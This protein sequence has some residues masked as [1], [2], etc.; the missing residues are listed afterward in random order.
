MGENV[1]QT[2]RSGK[3]NGFGF[4][5]TGNFF[6][7]KILFLGLV[8]AQIISS[9]H[10]YLSNI[11][12]LHSI[13]N[14]KAAG[15]LTVPNQNIIKSL[16]ELGPAFYGGI[17]FTLTTGALLSLL[18]LVSAFMWVRF[19]KR[20]KN[21]LIP[22]IAIWAGLIGEININGFSPLICSYFL[23]IPSVVFLIS[24]RYMP[25][26]QS[27]K[28]G[29]LTEIIPVIPV[30]AL[31][32][33]WTLQ[34]NSGIFTD[35]RDHLL[36]SNSL[37]T[38]INDFYYQYTLYPAEAIKSL[39]QKLI[40]TYKFD[41]PE[42]NSL[43]DQIRVKLVNNDYLQLNKN[44]EVD[45]DIE[46][47]NNY[48]ELR[49]E[50]K[51]ILTTLSKDF[52]SDPGKTLSEFS[53]RVDRQDFFRRFTFISL[54]SGFP[55]AM[56]I[57]FYSMLV[58]FL[59]LFF[60]YRRA[61]TISLY[62]CLAIAIFLSAFFNHVSGKQIDENNLPEALKSA[63]WQDKVMALRIID[64]KKLDISGF[65][66]YR[67]MLSSPHIPVRYWLAKVLGESHKPGTF[68]DLLVLMDD[69]SPNV[70]CM[71]YY[72]TGQR[73]SKKNIKE[74]LQRIK[75]SGHWYEQWY[76]YKA[77]RALGWKQTISD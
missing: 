54:L 36:L 56:I 10:V 69:P 67:E 34:I 63:R 61:S 72:S 29:G 35:I 3:T 68:K 9:I 2:D 47:Q 40:R 53:M 60:E 44:A 70:V 41:K 22:F 15:Y 50:G 66:N 25:P 7:G 39:D 19:F 21:L 62:L 26:P 64:E 14:I 11:K 13:E 16:P 65:G 28:T 33:L 73:G 31:V 37:G 46:E 4:F 43:A 48:I 12:L 38:K 42:D 20:K 32:I 55:A 23:F 27:R 71:A 74:L 51:I 52:L 76:A 24:S 45:L 59:K 57:L 75:I 6:T 8:V 58:F 18:G 30:L 17:F 49:H 77:L 1:K 5:L